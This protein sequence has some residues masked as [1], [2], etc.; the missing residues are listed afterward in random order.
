MAREYAH[1]DFPP[2][3]TSPY[4][5]GQAIRVTIP[6]PNDVDHEFHG[7]TGEIT[8]IQSDAAGATS[9]PYESFTYWVTLTET[10]NPSLDTDRRIP[11]RHRDLEA[12]KNR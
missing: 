5:H 12:L 9:D 6:D 2:V 4:I 1:G 10:A 11:L 3:Y 8:E 7:M